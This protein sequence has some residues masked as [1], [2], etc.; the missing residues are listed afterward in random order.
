MSVSNEVAC[1]YASS[2][3]YR[4]RGQHFAGGVF[5]FRRLVFL[6]RPAALVEIHGV[7]STPSSAL[8]HSNVL[9]SQESLSIMDHIVNFTAAE[10][11]LL[12][13]HVTGCSNVGQVRKS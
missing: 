11:I 7:F 5:V 13:L 1:V 12:L 9:G 4:C 8:C 3:I 10:F 2:I 6:L